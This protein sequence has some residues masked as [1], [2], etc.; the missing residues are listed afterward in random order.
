[1]RQPAFRWLALAFSLNS[2]V[3]VAVSIHLIPHLQDGGYDLALAATATGM[4]GAM[5]VL[6]RVVLALLDDRASLRTTTAITLAFQPVSMLVLLLVPGALGLWTFIALFGA[7]R[8]AMSLLRPAFVAS[9]YG[10]ERFASISGA[11]AAFVMT[12][13][14]LAP[15]SAGAFFDVVGSYDPLFWGFVWL[16]LLS[17]GVVLLVRSQTPSSEP[18][19]LP[20]PGRATR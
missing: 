2:F 4:I 5:Q 12:A 7:S 20:V 8:G 18:E 9:L 6:G 1:V 15:L 19:A 14:A 10:R 17:V 16:S 11:L 13:N 3:S